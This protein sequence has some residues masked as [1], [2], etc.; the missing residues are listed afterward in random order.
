MGRAVEFFIRVL[1]AYIT[2]E[3]V[4]VDVF[5]F[6]QPILFSLLF[7][8]EYQITSRAYLLITV[9]GGCDGAAGHMP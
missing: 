7:I 8:G 9:C 2:F 6:W 5:F 4:R 3:P 1:P